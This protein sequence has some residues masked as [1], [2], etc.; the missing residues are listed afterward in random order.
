MIAP[1]SPEIVF[2]VRVLIPR[3]GGVAPATR[4]ALLVGADDRETPQRFSRAYAEALALRGIA[5]DYRVLPG[6]GHDLL[7]D[8]DL[9]DAVRRMSADPAP[10]PVKNAMV[11]P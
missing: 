7:R 4:V 11:N 6:R 5:T 10:P 9:A 8:P 3:C 1:G 2:P